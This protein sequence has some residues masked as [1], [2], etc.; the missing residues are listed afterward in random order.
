M[1]TRS[2]PFLGLLVVTALIAGLS[3]KPAAACDHARCGFHAG[4]LVC[5]FNPSSHSNCTSDCA[6]CD[7][8]ACPP[9]KSGS[10]AQAT[11]LPGASLQCSLGADAWSRLAGP[12]ASVKVE[13]VKLKARS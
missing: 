5:I 4:C 1:K 13:V 12:T 2:L 9:I 6:S 3:A 10:T 11:L 8:V 7:Q